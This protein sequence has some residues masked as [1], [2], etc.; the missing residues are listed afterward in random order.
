VNL[1]ILLHTDS[2]RQRPTPPFLLESVEVLDALD[3]L[4][5]DLLTESDEDGWTVPVTALCDEDGE[6]DIRLFVD[7]S[8]GMLRLRRASVFRISRNQM[9]VCVALV[10]SSPPFIVLYSTEGKTDD[11]VWETLAKV[12]KGFLKTP[13]AERLRIG[14]CASLLRELLG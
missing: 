4:N 13:A 2:E 6:I 12:G 3:G 5:I 14:D 11:E 9:Q 8:D 1:D 7:G 10:E